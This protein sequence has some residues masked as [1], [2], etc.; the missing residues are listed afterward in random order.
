MFV[1]V[2][3]KKIHYQ[4]MGTGPPLLFVHGW[5]GTSTSLLPLARLFTGYEMIV[6]DLPGFGKSNLPDPKWG[7]QE[8][9]NLVSQFCLQLGLKNITYFGHS[10]GGSLGIYL[11]STKP[12]LFKKLILCNSAY[13]RTSPSQ[14]GFPLMKRLPIGMKRFLYRI[15]FPNSDSMKYPQLE[16]NFRKIITQDIT[17]LLSKIKVPTLILWGSADKDTPAPMAQELHEKIEESILKIFEGVT[18]GLPLKYPELVYKE[19]MKFL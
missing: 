13:K 11:A 1:D 9:A 4:K 5:G 19:I 3:G 14:S 2:S 15:F 10:F 17:H 8:Y 12:D 7:V 6:L 16:T 18:H